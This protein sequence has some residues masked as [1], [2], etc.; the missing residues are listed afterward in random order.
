MCSSDLDKAIAD[1]TIAI[2]SRQL[3]TENLAFAYYCRGN[4]YNNK[5]EYDKT[6]ADYTQAIESRQLTTEN[7][8]FAYD[9]QIGRASCRE[10]V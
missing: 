4:A 10:R 8:A 9:S 3:P 2:E 7:L 6:I 5:G 1:Y